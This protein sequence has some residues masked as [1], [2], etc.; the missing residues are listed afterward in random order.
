[1]TTIRHWLSKLFDKD[2]KMEELKH[3]GYF[4]GYSA[5]KAKK[6]IINKAHKRV[7]G[8]RKIWFTDRYLQNVSQYTI[9]GYEVSETV[10]NAYINLVN[11]ANRTDITWALENTPVDN[12]DVYFARCLF[13]NHNFVRISG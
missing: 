8:K 1:M 7:K 11:T 13:A 3:A 12:S 10:Y 9:D 4:L 2:I 5:G 6:I